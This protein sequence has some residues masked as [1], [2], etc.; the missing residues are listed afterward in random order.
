MN[1]T[2]FILAFLFTSICF[3][4]SV[5]FDG[6]IQDEQKNP[7]EMANIMAINVATKAMDSYGITNDKGKFQLTLKPNT[8]Y[9]IKVSYLG[10]KSKEIS[11]ATQS[12]NIAQNIV[13]DDAG[14]ELQGVE[15]VREMPVSIKGDTIVYNAD[16]FKSGTEKKLED[17]LKKLPGVEVNAD[18][19]IEV[20]G[21][22]VSKLMVEGKD[23]F[24]GDTKLGVKNIPADA[25]DK[26]QVLRNYNEVGALKGLG[27]DQDNV[28]MNIKLKEG[29]KNFWFGDVTAGTGVGELDS[30]YIINPKLFYY[31]PKYSINVITNFNN[32]GELPLTAQDYFK[33]TG[34]FKNMMQKGGSNF[35]ISSNDLGISILRN[36]RAKEI[37]TKF[38]ATNFAYSVT[39]KWNIS[40]FAILSTSKTDLETK[41]Q[42]TILDSGDEQKREEETHQKNNLGLFKLSSIYKPNDKFQFDYDIL[43]KLSKQNE[44]TDLLRESVVNKVSTLETILTNKKQDPTSI[45]QDLSLYYTQS[46]KNI[47]AFEMQHLYQDENPFYNANLRTQPFDLAGYTSGQQRNDLNQDR[48]VKTNKLDA[49][50]DYYYMVTPKSNINITLGNTF[51]YQD[52]NSHIFQMLDNGDRND[53]DDP[54]NNN[55]VNY[56]FNDVFLGFH[57]KILAGKFTLTPGVSVHSYNMKNTQLGTD[58]SQNFVK[59]LPDFFALYQIKKSESLTYNFSLTNDFT[60]I[61]QLAAGYVLSD[62]SSLF[63][64][65]RL[66]ENATSQVHSLRYFKYNM[67][68]FEN[69]FANATYTKKVDA[70]KTSADFTGINQSS[71]PYNSNLADETFT[72]M[73]N[74]GRSFLKNYK[75]SVNAT[76]NWSKFNNIQNNELATTESFSQSYTVKASTN[77]KNLPNIE[78]GYNA[79]INKYSGS[80]YY[81]DKPFARLDYYFLDSFSFVSE[82]EFYHYYNGNKT[83][84]NEY[85]FLS[86]SLIYQKKDSKW[87]YKI[88]ATN[89][90]NTKYL[91]DDSFSQFSTRVSQYTVQPRYIIFSMKYNL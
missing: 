2:L 54:Q 85:D 60:D 45:K 43:T 11:I 44:D 5:R 91:N 22:K 58:Y 16:S 24:D 7:L 30:R 12:A 50:L 28:A 62:Y 73:G 81:T 42:T 46:D 15:I 32:I 10:M 88:S 18:G 80:T 56:N 34:G 27:N 82:Y 37:E 72:G 67:F 90:L 9:S 23:F 8:S 63:R 66:L 78:F 29:K 13:M 61:N 75:A 39:K 47:F 26:I 20:E 17:V 64:G 65:N 77:Y 52:F 1:K 6:F 49:K 89:L 70:I 41:S 40:G 36:N 84:D 35:N 3:S 68:N 86:A 57:Y 21:K 53:L 79:L 38:G 14:I 55:K 19:E 69:I 74:Y 76:F 48:F 71:S 25:I 83:V 33:F 87:E 59:I 51:S 4:Q 31:S